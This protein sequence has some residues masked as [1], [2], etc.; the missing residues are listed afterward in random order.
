[1]LLS[2]CWSSSTEVADGE[3]EVCHQLRKSDFEQ[4]PRKR[5]ERWR[6]R[7]FQRDF[8]GACAEGQRQRL[9]QGSI[10][11]SAK[12]SSRYRC[13][14]V[15][16]PVCRWR[17]LAL[18]DPGVAR[19]VPKWSE[20]WQRV[21]DRRRDWQWQS[22]GG[23]ASGTAS[24]ARRY[25]PACGSRSIP[26]HRSKTPCLRW[27]KS[28]LR[29]SRILHACVQRGARR[30]CGWMGSICEGPRRHAA[31]QRQQARCKHRDVTE[32]SSAEGTVRARRSCRQWP[33]SRFRA[34]GPQDLLLVQ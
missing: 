5:Q 13:S 29:A 12:E 4:A 15:P 26:W 18:C 31:G 11:S 16:V 19:E 23:R 21:L 20:G 14:K 28:A 9:F 10:S 32:D 17:I 34:A 3:D 30:Q 8:E 2:H 22:C 27:R 33:T 24:L 7:F 25:L 6:Q 1:M